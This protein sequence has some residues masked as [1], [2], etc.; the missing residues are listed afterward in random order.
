MDTNRQLSIATSLKV[1]YSREL[2]RLQKELVTHKVAENK[3]D[4]KEW[5]AK[6]RRVRDLLK[7][8]NQ[9]I[10]AIKRSMK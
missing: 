5:R 7:I 10:R 8:F 1:I 6:I 2:D 4:I 3:E 9:E